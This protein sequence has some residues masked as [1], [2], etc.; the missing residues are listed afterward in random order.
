MLDHGTLAPGGRLPWNAPVAIT[1][2]DGSQQRRRGQLDLAVQPAGVL[3]D[4]RVPPAPGARV[5]VS[6]NRLMARLEWASR[7][8][9][10]LRPAA[11]MLPLLSGS[12]EGRWHFAS[13]RWLTP[14]TAT[15]PWLSFD[16]AGDIDGALHIL[17]G[18]LLPGSHVE[19]PQVS[20]AAGLLGNVF[21]GSARAQARVLATSSGAR[22]VVGLTV[23]RFA[24][25][26]RG[27]AR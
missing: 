2:A 20:L 19:V 26:P 22:S 12:I 24:L 23:D 18:Q 8:P 3:L 11:E 9:L 17:S 13:L 4:V 14:L 7:R 27:A 16:G 5:G 6:P 15:R 1:E 25:A 21:G 10:P